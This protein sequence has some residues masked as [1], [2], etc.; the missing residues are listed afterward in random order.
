LLGLDRIMWYCSAHLQSCMAI[1]LK[2]HH[3]RAKIF[4]VGS[5]DQNGQ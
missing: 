5:I 2:L 3:D 4:T 1:G